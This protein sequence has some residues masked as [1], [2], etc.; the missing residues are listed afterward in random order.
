MILHLLAREAKIGEAIKSP[1][2]KA[3]ERTPS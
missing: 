1:T 3:D 2:I